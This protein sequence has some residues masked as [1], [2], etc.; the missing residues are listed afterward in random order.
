MT[1]RSKYTRTG[2]RLSNRF[3]VTV[4]DLPMGFDVSAVT[5]D[6]KSQH[7]GMLEVTCRQGLCET[8][9]IEVEEPFRRQRV[10]TALYE[11]ALDEICK[12]RKFMVSDITRSAFA[13]AFWRKQVARGRAKCLNDALPGRYF[14]GRDNSPD[15]PK[16][17]VEP[18]GTRTWPCARWAM[19]PN[20][21]RPSSAEVDL[22]GLLTR[23]RAAVPVMLA[24]AALGALA[25]QE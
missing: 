8:G 20:R 23:N 6:E 18:D 12:R 16:P 14:E 4:T 15:L 1:R 9:L 3:R 22:S 21:C 7:A 24:V 2:L 17:D 10:G 13:E 25:L 19:D 11:A 5:A